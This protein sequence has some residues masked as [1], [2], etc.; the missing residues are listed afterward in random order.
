LRWLPLLL[1]FGT[2]AVLA[3]PVVAMLERTGVIRENYRGHRLP[4][5][6]GFLIIAAALVALAPLSALDELVDSDTLHPGLGRILA[7]ALGVALI[8]LVDDLLGTLPEPASGEPPPRG[9]RAHGRA[10]FEGSLSTGAVK[11]AGTLGLALFVTSGTGRSAGEYLIA[12]GVLVLSTHAFNLLD[13][14]P[15]RALKLFVLLGIAVTAA[16]WDSGPLE[17]LGLLVGPTL[18]LLPYDLRERAML[19]D[20]GSNVVGATAGLWI[21]LA[22]STAGQ[23]VALAVLA[24][25][26]TYGEFRS[27]S[28]LVERSPLLRRLDSIGRLPLETRTEQRAVARPVG[29]DG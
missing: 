18:V 8:G 25:V 15:G 6:S 9:L 26:A 14:R 22:L 24:A 28:A 4:A 11:A 20:V 29:S 27:I 10:A 21:I 19:G 16:T 2:A 5:A 13:L 3:R 1:S 12:V 7:Y 23:A 17:R